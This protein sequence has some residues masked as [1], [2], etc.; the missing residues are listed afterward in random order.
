MYYSALE[1]AMQ[2]NR[3]SLLSFAIGAVWGAVVFIMIF[4]ASV[5]VPTNTNWL[6]AYVGDATQ[7]QL[8]WEFYRSSGFSFP[9]GLTEGLS[10][11]GKVSCLYSDS[12]PLFAM[13]FKPLSP[14]LPDNFQY[15]GLW[16][17]LCFALNGGCGA[18]LLYRIKPD[19]LFASVGSLF[20]SLFP[21]TVD[22]IMHHNS[23]GAVWLIILPLI[24]VLDRNKEHRHRFTYTLYWCAVCMLAAS[25]HPYFLPMIFTVM[26]GYMILAI[27]RDK[28]PK[29]AFITAGA[30]AFSSVLALFLIG[31]FHGSGKYNDGGFGF[32]SSNLNTFFNSMGRSVYLNG[33]DALEGQTEGFGYLGLGA[34]I[35]CLAAIAAVIIILI[36]KEGTFRHNAAV[37]IKQHSVEVIAFAAVFFVSFFWAVS[38]TVT[39]GSRTVADIPLPWLIRGC[40]GVFRASGRFIWLPGILLTTAALAGISRLGKRAAVVTAVLCVAVQVL[41][42]RDWHSDQR[43]M[44]AKQPDYTFALRDEK[45]DELTEN[46]DEIVFL[47]MKTQYGLYMDMYFDF[48][49]LAVKKDMRLSSFYLARLDLDAVSEYSI[50][51]YNALKSGSGRKNVLY[52]FFDEA[53]AVPE[54]DTLGVYHIDGYTV[55]K[56]K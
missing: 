19:V 55:A 25:I 46:T 32:Y 5:I 24:L 21:P 1:D 56:V 33:L 37:L 42:M 11:E 38:T 23:L 2:N 40:L 54:T 6:F 50:R 20:Y 36:R 41:D 26:T 49:Q 10:S 22:R 17:V 31:A 52:V 14:V 4:G 53:D 15:F 43:K 12:L 45:W 47:P 29:T 44:F 9:P 3:K 16:G 34:L 51:E 30:S 27:F 7:H 8:G 28:T 48:A 18:A 35:C 13:I 39:L